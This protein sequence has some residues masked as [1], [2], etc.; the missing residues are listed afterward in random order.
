LDEPLV[1]LEKIG[2]S[3]RL[4]ENRIRWNVGN[5]RSI[6]ATDILSAVRVK[7][8]A[9]HIETAETSPRDKRESE[10]HTR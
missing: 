6:Y 10:E 5:D 4:A 2:R 7:A 9:I 1:F 3:F 8:R